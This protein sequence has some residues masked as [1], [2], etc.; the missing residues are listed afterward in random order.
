MGI[1]FTHLSVERNRFR[2]V[3]SQGGGIGACRQNRRGVT[4]GF[5]MGI[6]GERDVVFLHLPFPL[7][8]V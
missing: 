7:L 8:F 3:A 6:E 2:H 5:R 1:Q 4:N